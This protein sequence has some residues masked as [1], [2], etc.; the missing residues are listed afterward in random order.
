MDAL[1]F[2]CYEYYCGNQYDLIDIDPFGSVYDCL[3]F[4]IKMAKK[5]IIVTYGEYGHKRWKRYDTVRP[6]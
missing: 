5:G 3:Q 4:A 1:K 6:T 2:C